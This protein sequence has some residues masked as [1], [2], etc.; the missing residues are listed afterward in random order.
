MSTLNAKNTALN[1]LAGLGLG[2]AGATLAIAV[3]WYCEVMIPIVRSGY[4]KAWEID[5]TWLWEFL[6]VMA[7]SVIMSTICFR[8]LHTVGDAE[9][10]KRL[11]QK[12][13][14]LLLITGVCL[15]VV[16]RNLGGSALLWYDIKVMESKGIVYLGD[17]II[18]IGQLLTMAIACAIAG[19]CLF[20]MEDDL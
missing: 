11:S 15:G 19:I 3:K 12:N 4:A 5:R 18:T 8:K 16:L 13:H 1:I 20:R 17:S 9:W 10:E 14:V 7:A 2:V 6:V